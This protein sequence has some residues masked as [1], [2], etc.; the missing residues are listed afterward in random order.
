MR[1]FTGFPFAYVYIDSSFDQYVSVPAM[2]C[3]LR[4]VIERVNHP[5]RNAM[6]TTHQ[7]DAAHIIAKA[8]N[9][10]GDDP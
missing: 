4:A 9:I 10:D 3:G 2:C 7:D 6:G 5:K 1:R 8:N